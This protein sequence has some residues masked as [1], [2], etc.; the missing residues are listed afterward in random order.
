M[1]RIVKMFWK[2]WH[3]YD[4][5]NSFISICKIIKLNIIWVILLKFQFVQFAN[6]ACAFDNLELSGTCYPCNTIV[7]AW[8][9][10]DYNGCLSCSEGLYLVV[11]KQVWVESWDLAII[12]STDANQ[13]KYFARRNSRKWYR[14]GVEWTNCFDELGWT[15]IIQDPTLTD[16]TSMLVSVGDGNAKTSKLWSDVITGWK[17]WNSL[18]ICTLSSSRR[19]HYKDEYTNLDIIKVDKISHKISE[20]SKGDSDYKDIYRNLN[21]CLTANW[22]T[23]ASS[24]SI[25][26]QCNSGY[27]LES[28]TKCTSCISN[29]LVWSNV[30]S[31]TQWNSNTF[32]KESSG[33]WISSWNSNEY[34]KISTVK[35][36]VVTPK[37]TKIP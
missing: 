22:M 7:P 3:N 20:I 30:S 21:S 32:V 16:S 4:S 17:R 14:C 28:S 33:A 24:T 37:M 25:W 5:S 10:C 26:D 19:L 31:C 9:Q 8:Q 12:P 6:A 1:S 2:E 34:V 18:G 29:W 23:C 35:A 36:F 11:D 27:F 13:S 15:D